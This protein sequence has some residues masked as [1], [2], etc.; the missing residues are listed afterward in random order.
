MS[1]NEKRNGQDKSAMRLAFKKG[2]L[3]AIGGVLL[4]AGLVLALFLPGKGKSIGRAEIYRD[5]ELIRTVPLDRDTEFTV[6]GAYTNVITVRGGRIAV[7]EADCPGGDCVHSGW[8]GSPGRSLACLPNRVEIRVVS[9]G[10]DAD[11]DIITG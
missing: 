1:G 2:D 5:G 6:S 3:F 9:G 8:I 7:T 10:S 4:L 11:V